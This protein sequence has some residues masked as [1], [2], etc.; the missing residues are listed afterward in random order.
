[1]KQALG[2]IETK[3]LIAAITAADA[4]AKAAN[5]KI[6]GKEKITAA[7]V[8]IKIIGEVA[9]VKAAVEAGVQAAKDLGEIISVH[10]IPRPDDEIDKIISS[11]LQNI[12]DNQ[13]LEVEDLL[14]SDIDNLHYD[15]IK[16]LSVENL[17]KLARQ[18]S[19]FPLKGRDI[20]K[21]NKE[22]LLSCFKS[23]LKS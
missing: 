9:A 4:M 18:F 5:V 7:K 17:R 8:T 13:K 16:D 23:I 6:I 10:V 14:I 20:S 1:M 12:E 19:D 2:L 11:N 21:S 15:N 3:G 22:T